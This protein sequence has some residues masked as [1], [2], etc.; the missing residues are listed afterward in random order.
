MPVSLHLLGFH[1]HRHS[2]LVDIHASSTTIIPAW[3]V[4]WCKQQAGVRYLILTNT[5]CHMHD[6]KNLVV[7]CYC[8]TYTWYEY[9]TI[10]LNQ[11]W[12][13][14][15]Q[16]FS[17]FSSTLLVLASSRVTYYSCRLLHDSTTASSSILTHDPWPLTVDPWPLTLDACPFTCSVAIIRRLLRCTLDGL[18]QADGRHPSCSIRGG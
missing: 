15:S 9:T 18:R 7:W 14:S 12:P 6:L 13:P 1:I 4:C 17:P 11:A 16:L 8:Y 10:L 3:Q 2:L 5:T